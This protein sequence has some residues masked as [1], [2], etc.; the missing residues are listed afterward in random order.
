MRGI[1]LFLSVV[2]AFFCFSCGG[3]SSS[4]TTPVSKI[5]KRAFVSNQISNSVEIVDAAKDMLS[6]FTIT[7]GSGPTVMVESQDK[8]LTLVFNSAGNTLA[9]IDNATET[10]KNSLNLRDATDSFAIS[11]DNRFIYV[12]ERNTLPSGATFPGA[13]EIFDLNNVSAGST[14]VSVPAALALA[15]SHNGGTLLVFSDNSDDVNV[16]NT[17]NT[18]AGA[19]PIHGFHRPIF[20]VFTSDDSTAYV[21]NCGAE[22]GGTMAGVASFSVST[23]SIAGTSATSFPARTAL[24]NGGTL[25]VAGTL[26]GNPP[27]GKLT[28]VDANTLNAMPSVPISDGIHDRVVLGS[29][30]KLFVGSRA[31]SNLTQGCLAIYDTTTNPPTAVIHAPF[32]GPSGTPLPG[33]VTGIEAI[34]GRNIVY[35]CE[36]GELNIYDTTSNGLAKGSTIDIVGKAVDVKEVF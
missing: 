36:G 34:P 24:L 12:A 2:A 17:S 22:C 19:T 1:A 10:V 6:T 29:N 3:G 33:D 14:L 13:V 23:Q 8:K 28:V 31:C 18:A 26:P 15:L 9:E 32:V 4:N 7:P 5:A 27:S 16:I 21:M 25:Y 11:S 35:V 20:A 30:G